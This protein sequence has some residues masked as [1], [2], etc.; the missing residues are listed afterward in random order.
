MEVLT[1]TIACHE[2]RPPADDIFAYSCCPEPVPSRSPR[3]GPGPPEEARAAACAGRA[4]G[5][6][7]RGGDRGVAAEGAGD[8]VAPSLHRPSPG[9]FA[10][11]PAP[12]ADIQGEPCLPR[13]GKRCYPIGETETRH[14]SR[15]RPRLG[16]PRARW[17]MLPHA[18][19][20]ARKRNSAH[21]QRRTPDDRCPLCC[22][23]TLS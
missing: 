13:A 16:A 1:L 5:R 18:S 7:D 6:R 12:I 23:A 22:G 21:R 20:H 4:A 3:P 2:G 19:S 10:A 11:L 8:S 14:G 9:W 15:V 17:S